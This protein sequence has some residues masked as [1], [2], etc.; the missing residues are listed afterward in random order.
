MLEKEIQKVC[1]QWL[2]ANG[3]FCWRN[4]NVGVYHR[5]I[6]KYV[7]HGMKGVPDLV[8][9]LPPHSMLNGKSMAGRFLG[10]EIKRPGNRLSDDQTIWHARAAE[11]GAVAICVWSLDELINDM[12]PILNPVQPRLEFAGSPA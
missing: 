9:M 6:D 12:T 1:L 4:N 5:D 10:V 8:G 7:F 3:V 11:N 2:Q